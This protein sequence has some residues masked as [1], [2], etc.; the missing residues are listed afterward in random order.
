MEKKVYLSSFCVDF[1]DY[2]WL[3]NCIDH[4]EDFP[5]GVEFATWWVKQQD[6]PERLDQ[7]VE[8]FR[9]IP[10]T[11]HAPFYEICNEDGSE[12]QKKMK[13]LFDHACKQYHAFNATSIVIHTNEGSFP[14]ET[15]RLS[16]QRILELYEE[17]KAQ[18]MPMTVENVG[19]PAKNNC[20]FPY[21]DFIA[22]FDELPEEI[23]C[24]IDTGHAMLNGWDIVS[25]IK[26]LGPRIRGYHLNGTD[27]IHDS[28]FP[29]FDPRGCYSE[30][31]MEEV[32]A[33]IA[34]YSPDADLILEYA[35]G[36]HI[37]EELMHTEIRRVIEIM[38]K[39][40]S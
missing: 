16:V 38:E 26:T 28:H 1:R 18:G 19:Y 33:A 20:L 35:P 14:K 34:K 25:L 3:R 9:G 36:P 4:F 37:T 27:G 32:I 31:Q 29:C 13:Q 7:Q 12:G 5:V 21:E 24:L 17:F 6:M 22:L 11:I 8:L 30:Q 40:L 23:G 2:Q 15:Q 10:A 39:N